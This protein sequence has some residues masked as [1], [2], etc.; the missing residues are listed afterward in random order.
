MEK[1]IKQEKGL[2]NRYH[3]LRNV[4]K[5]LEHREEQFETEVLAK[6]D[7]LDLQGIED[8]AVEKIRVQTLREQLMRFLE[9]YEHKKW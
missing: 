7:T 8:L 6:F 5:K 3:R 9:R 1:I 2:E 4:I